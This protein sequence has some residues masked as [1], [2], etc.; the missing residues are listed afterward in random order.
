MKLLLI[1]PNDLLRHPIPNRMFHI[2]KRLA[3]KHE[4]ILLSYTKHPLASDE[5][6]RAFAGLEISPGRPVPAKNLGL[7]YVMNAAQIHGA[8]KNVLENGVDAV[9]HANILPSLIATQLAKKLKIPAI[10]DYLD[11]FPESAS[12]YYTKGKWIV[13]RGVWVITTRALRNSDVVIVPSYG[14]KAAIRKVI[15]HIPVYVIPNGVDAEVFK[16]IDQKTARKMLNLDTEYHLVLLQGSIDVWID[17]LQV[18]KAINKLRQQL[19]IGDTCG[20][21]LT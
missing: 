6:R 5:V 4:I 2:A 3:K 17:I 7:Y 20:R 9:I 15:P 8:V 14:I 13:E 16:P 10:Y 19:D 11:Y 21:F 1:P 12:A 18:L